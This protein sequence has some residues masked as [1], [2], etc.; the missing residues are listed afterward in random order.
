V[1]GEFDAF[2]APYFQDNI[3]HQDYLLT[4][5]AINPTK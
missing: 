3:F 4:R 5:A 2:V 1:R